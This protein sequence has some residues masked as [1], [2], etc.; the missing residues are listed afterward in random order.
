MKKP[1][2][3]G[4]VT[5]LGRPNVGKSTLMNALIGQKVAIVSPKAQTTRNRITGVLTGDG[6]QAVFLDTPGIHK[7]RTELG[8]TMMKSVKQALVDTEQIVFVVDASDVR[9]ADTDILEKYKVNKVAR[10][11]VL[12]K[13]DLVEKQNLLSLI[14]RF[15]PYDFTA[16]IPVSAK[17]GDGLDDLK[18]TIADNLPEGPQYFP[19]DAITDRP[20]R[21]ITAELI[22]EKALRFLNEEIPHGIG[23]EILQMQKAPTG[24]MHI[25]ATVYCE[26][27]S[28]KSMIIGKGGSMIGKIGAAA[29]QEIETLLDCRVNLKLWV[30]VVPDWR[31]RPAELRNLGY[32]EEKK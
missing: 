31:N 6:W 3:S 1:F 4:F 9:S 26:R 21:F 12:N 10:V 11:L 18:K 7:P 16:I 23:V 25:E 28:H 29:R 17:T 5:I 13:I 20:E 8:N 30:K 14:Q 19:D 15:A 2:K 27:D 22:R 32:D 24:V